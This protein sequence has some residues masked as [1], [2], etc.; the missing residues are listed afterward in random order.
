MVLT[1]HPVSSSKREAVVNDLISLHLNA[2]R[3]Y[4]SVYTR[5]EHGYL[6]VSKETRHLPF[7]PGLL[8]NIL[9]ENKNASTQIIKYHG[10]VKTV[11]GAICFR[12]P[13]PKYRGT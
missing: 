11:C 7:P 13:N 8:E 5:Q 10:I 2:L 4:R 9:T 3:H 6:K 12:A 1:F